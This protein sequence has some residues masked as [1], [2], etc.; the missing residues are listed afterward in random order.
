MNAPVDDVSCACVPAAVLPQLASLRAHAGIRIRLVGQRAWLWWTTGDAF[1]LERI[2]AL[3]GTELFEL[4]DGLWYRP[5]Q[6]VPAFDVPDE[7]EARPLAHLLT[8]AAVQ[9]ESGE[10]AVVP[11]TIGLVRDDRPR[12]ATALCCLLSE[13]SRWAT[14]ATSKQLEAL[15]AVYA[16][17]RVLLRGRRLPALSAG[18]CYWGRGILVP[19]GFRVRPEL[20]EGALREAL[21]LESHEI[22]LLSDAGFEVIDV[23]LFQPLT[24][25]SVRLALREGM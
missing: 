23:R 25:A 13:L 11:L 8:P 9:A 6:H 4:R 24:R 15:E 3:H 20:S 1:V 10:P 21:G 2:L 7:D 14:Q 12:P 18:E 22:A 16:G 17:E 19:L 5:G